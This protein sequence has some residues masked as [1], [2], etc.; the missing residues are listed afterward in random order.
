MRAIKIIFKWMANW[1]ARIKPIFQMK[2]T[3]KWTAIIGLC[4]I[5]V[6][7]FL[8]KKNPDREQKPN[9]RKLESL[10]YL[11]WVKA[12]KSLRKRGV[13]RHLKGEISPGINFYNS[14]DQ[15]V[16]N[17]MT[18]DGR[19]LHQWE[20]PW[21][22]PKGWHHIHICQNGDILGIIKDEALVCLNWDSDLKWR[23]NHRFHHDISIADSGDIY[24]LSRKEGWVWY[25]GWPFPIIIDC[26][27]VLSPTGAVKREMPIYQLFADFI[28]R[29]KFLGIYQWLQTRGSV[30]RMKKIEKRSG[31]RLPVTN[32]P[33]VL[34][35]NSLQVIDRDIEG[36][37]GKGDILLSLREIDMI[38]IIDGQ[39]KKILW[40]W[41]PG[42]LL[43]QHHPTLLENN[44]ILIFDNGAPKRRYSRI[45][46]M[47][48]LTGKIVWLYRGNKRNR[49]YSES[50][51]GCQRLPNGNTLITDSESGRVFE[52]ASNG[53]MVWHFYNPRINMRRKSRAAIYRM[54]RIHDVKKYPFLTRFDILK[55]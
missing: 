54:I 37:C 16:A 22:S 9:K 42:I 50:R 24:T 8:L 15:R 21:N 5:L 18:M 47:D 3:L 28:P 30:A 7:L 53:R 27:L 51:G 49:F 11:T 19:I 17:L 34:H 10:S 48:P 14:R 33:D 41:G 26:I 23:C 29:E 31:Y 12:H 1:A 13:V 38:A 52:V 6:V 2:T 43:R 46:E 44:N 32:P 20:Y 36:L 25:D 45:M 55:N 40:R 4:L 39:G 35:T